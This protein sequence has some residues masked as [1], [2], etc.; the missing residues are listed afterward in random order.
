VV[1][2]FFFTHEILLTLTQLLPSIPGF[3]ATVLLDGILPVLQKFCQTSKERF[4]RFLSFQA[5]KLGYEHLSA[6]LSASSNNILPKRV[7]FVIEQGLELIYQ[8]WEDPFEGIVNLI[9]QTFQCIIEIYDRT[10]NNIDLMDK[11]SQKTDDLKDFI[12]QTTQK[13]LHLDPNTKG[14]YPILIILVERLGALQVQS[15]KPDLLSDLYQAMSNATLRKQ[16]TR[17][18]ETFLKQAQKE[19]LVEKDQKVDETLIYNLWLP[20][21]VKAL[22][23][24]RSFDG[25][26]SYTLPCIMELFPK[27]L[28]VLI[29]EVCNF[30]IEGVPKGYLSIKHIRALLALIKQGR[31][32]GLIDS[33]SLEHI[34]DGITNEN[35]IQITDYAISSQEDVI[36]LD[37]LQ[38]IC[39]SRKLTEAPTDFELKIFASFLSL[40]MED[41]SASYRQVKDIMVQKMVSRIRDS[42]K[43]NYKVWLKKSQNHFL[44]KNIIFWNGLRIYCSFLCIQIVHILE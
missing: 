5:I 42:T 34:L 3:P 19:L 35:I 8:N 29:T 44:E 13:L 32:L 14:K 41:A 10:I 4:S 11:N 40:N 6:N 1:Y 31:M 23:S 22:F 30:P 18:L 37:A 28:T 12:E 27:C 26:V 36:K 39:N 7:K 2:L 33:S 15:M 38:I 25:I 20:N 24:E 17:L 16:V 9:R 43:K 21:F